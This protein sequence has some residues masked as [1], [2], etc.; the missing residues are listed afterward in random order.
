MR[1]IGDIVRQFE[2]R[3]RSAVAGFIEPGRGEPYALATLVRAHGSSYRR[4]GARMM[5]AAD[6]GV[7]GSLSGGCLEEEVIA[8]AQQVLRTGEPAWMEFDTRRRFGCHGA[9]EI[10]VE[11]A[12]PDF[13]AELAESYHARRPAVLVTCF[14]REGAE[15]GTR[16]TNSEEN[17]APDTFTQRIVPPVQ[18]LVIGE[19]PDSGALRGL[20]GTLGWSVVQLENATELRSE[21]DEWTAAVVKTHNYGRDCAALRALLPLGLHYIGLLGPR[22]RRDQLLG[23]ILDSGVAVDGNI[24]GPAGLDLGGDAPEA[25]ALSIIAEIQA[26][27]AGGSGLP[28]RERRAPIHAVAA[29]DAA[30]AF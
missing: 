7:V 15:V 18:L 9:L 29:R 6:G 4:P 23:D 27:F 10:F 2:Q 1:E 28:L 14:A 13:F 22:R 24:F 5:V 17:D 26:V 8:R 3:K 16:F 12:L 20:G 30:L 21:Y 11:R 25:I 19:G